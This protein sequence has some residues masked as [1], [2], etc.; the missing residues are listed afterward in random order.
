MNFTYLIDVNL[1]AGLTVDRCIFSIETDA[2]NAAI[3]VWHSKGGVFGSVTVG[4]DT[5]NNFGIPEETRYRVFVKSTAGAWSAGINGV[6]LMSSTTSITTAASTMA[7][8]FGF[9]AGLGRDSINL[10]NF[11]SYDFELTDEEIGYA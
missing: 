5:V 9:Y 4:G 1:V 11:K 8:N 6:V 2:S 7:I 10:S 3:V